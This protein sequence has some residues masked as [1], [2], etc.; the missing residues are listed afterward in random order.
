MSP[1]QLLRF[2]EFEQQRLLRLGPCGSHRWWPGRQPEALQSLARGVKRMH[3]REDLHR[4][5]AA[6]RLQHIDGRYSTHQHG[7]L[8]NELKVPEQN[9]CRVIAPTHFNLIQQPRESR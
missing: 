9:A 8:D 3:L 6:R 7:Q 1:V 5:L 4:S 2:I